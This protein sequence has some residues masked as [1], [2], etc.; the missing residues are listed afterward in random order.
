MKTKAQIVQELLAA[1]KISAEDAVILLTG[2]EK[3]YIFV[4][5]YPY[6]YPYPSYPIHTGTGNTLPMTFTI[7]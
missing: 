2:N 3:E 5:H 6:P 4:P 7:N 1:D